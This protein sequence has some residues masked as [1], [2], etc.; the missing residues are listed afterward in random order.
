[1]TAA[2]NRGKAAV[3]LELQGRSSK[4][5]YA[6]QHVV[7]LHPAERTVLGTGRMRAAMM[8]LRRVWS[9]LFARLLSL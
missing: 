8:A 3:R 9:G 5:S 4:V 2:L 6:D 7:E 1:M